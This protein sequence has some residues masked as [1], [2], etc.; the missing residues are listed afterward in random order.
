MPRTVALF[1]GLMLTA[2]SE[3]RWPVPADGQMVSDLPMVQKRYDG[4]SKVSLGTPQDIIDINSRVRRE[5]LNPKEIRWLSP[6]EAMVLADGM[7][8]GYE[9]CIC[10][11]VKKDGKWR[12]IESYLALVS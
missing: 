6:I 7:G 12:M 9:Q 11:L 8:L 10:V 2:C 1:L 5:Q 3:Q 4:G